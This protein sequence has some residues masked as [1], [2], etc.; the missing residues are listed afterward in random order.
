MVS[1]VLFCGQL[2]RALNPTLTIQNEAIQVI[3]V[4]LEQFHGV[5]L[6]ITTY[7]PS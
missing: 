1:L 5:L 3:R 7:K 2:V 6:F 4:A